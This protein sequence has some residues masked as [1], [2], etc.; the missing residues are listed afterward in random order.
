VVIRLPHG[1]VIEVDGVSP[2]WVAALARELARS[3]S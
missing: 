1:V 3:A 2:T